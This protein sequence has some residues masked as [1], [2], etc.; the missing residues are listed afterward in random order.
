MLIPHCQIFSLMQVITGK[1]QM[2]LINVSTHICRHFDKRNN[3]CRLSAQ[4][5]FTRSGQWIVWMPYYL[6]WYIKTQNAAEFFFFFWR[7]PTLFVAMIAPY[8]CWIPQLLKC[9]NLYLQIVKLP[10]HQRLPNGGAAKQWKG[11]RGVTALA[12]TMALN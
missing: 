1:T 2:L 3:Y 5:M 10:Q 9:P 6:D 8:D 7:M 4:T 11:G 12:S